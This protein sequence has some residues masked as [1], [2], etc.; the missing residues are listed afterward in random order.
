LLDTGASDTLIDR[1]VAAEH[2]L[3]KDGTFNIAAMS[4]MVAAENSVVKRLEIGKLIIND[5]PVKIIDLSGQSKHLGRQDSG[6]IGM[7]VI[8]RY[9]VTLDYSKPAM[10]LS[11]LRSL[12]MKRPTSRS[13]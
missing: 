6:I 11:L 5:I 10:T 13:V 8:G 1:R 9:L 12:K 7:N 3:P 2:F 4:G